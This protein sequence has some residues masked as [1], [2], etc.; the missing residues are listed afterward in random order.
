MQTLEHLK[1]EIDSTRN[2]YSVVKS[3]KALASVNIHQ[4]QNVVHALS[5]YSQT[6]EMGFQAV[7]KVQPDIYGNLEAIQ[8]NPSM[9]QGLIVFGTE[10]GLCGQINQQTLQYTVEK[11]QEF[12]SQQIVSKIMVLGTHLGSMFSGEKIVLD[13][14]LAQPNSPQGISKTVQTLI[15]HL[16]EWQSNHQVQQV[17]LIFNHPLSTSS[18]QI[19]YKQILPFNFEWVQQLRNKTWPTN[20]IPRYHLPTDEL[21]QALIREYIFVSLAKALA[22]SLASENISRM[23]T[24][25]RAEEN[26]SNQ[27]KILQD[28]HNNARQSMINEELLDI[29][30]GYQILTRR[31][32]EKQEVSP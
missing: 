31:S 6:I 30:S 15:M 20:Q 14:C 3:M 13:K 5:G 17:F 19:Q 21:V 10:Q 2:L 24:M 28:R 11:L 18:Y 26:I 4:F 12:Q 25:Q 23:L 7:L 27:L 32:P 1:K 8:T 29:V 9:P 16:E 22:D